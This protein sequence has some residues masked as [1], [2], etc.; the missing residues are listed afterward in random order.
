MQGVYFYGDF[1]SGNIWGL[2]QEVNTWQ[3]ALLLDTPHSV[4]TF[5]EDELGNIYLADY[6]NG[7]IYMIKDIITSTPTPSSTPASTQT[8]NPGEMVKLV[9]ALS[10]PLSQLERP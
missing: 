6:S 9:D 1:C 4:S 3:N 7:D 5:G 8:P 2:K 10:A